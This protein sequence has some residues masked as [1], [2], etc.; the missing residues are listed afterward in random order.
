MRRP[1]RPTTA[2]PARRDA[3]RVHVLATVVLGGAL[4]AGAGATPPAAP[5]PS[6]Q[7]PPAAGVPDLADAP[8]G[9]AELEPA[10]A[11]RELLDRVAT[12][13]RVVTGRRDLGVVGRSGAWARR[14]LRR[15]ARWISR[16]LVRSI[17]GFEGAGRGVVWLALALA[18]AAVGVGLVALL[19]RPRRRRPRRGEPAAVPAAPDGDPV[20]PAVDAAGWRAEV[21]RRLAAGSVAGA[22]E[23]VWWW[24]ARAVAGEEADP[25]WTGRELVRRARRPELHPPVARLDAMTYGPER[26]A[27]AAVRE[28]AAALDRQLGGG[29]PRSGA[30]VGVAR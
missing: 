28:L 8:S 10:A 15:L 18:A 9:W 22:L 24:L 3:R 29:G 30:A 25:S 12:E 13:T 23:A 5:S 26:P 20:P 7:Q 2:R 1:G 14:V 17:S 16:W 21:E 11:D 4:A 6:F 19:R 27:P